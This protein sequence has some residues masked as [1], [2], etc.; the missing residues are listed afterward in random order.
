MTQFDIWTFDF[1]KKGEHPCVLISHP[2]RCARA[3][4][5]NVLYC[6]SQKQN[7]QPYPFEVALDIED[8]LN[9]ETFCD[10]SLLWSIERAGLFNQRGRVTLERRRTMRVKVRDLLRLMGTD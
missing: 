8:G 7:R 2:D 4:V 10:C 1:P 9:W 5:V 3:E 6:T